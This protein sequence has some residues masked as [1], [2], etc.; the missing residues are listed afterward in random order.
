[1]QLLGFLGR[2]LLSTVFWVPSALAADSREKQLYG[3]HEHVLLPEFD[4]PL[5]AKLDTGAKTASLHAQGI[6]RFKRGGKSWVRFYLGTDSEQVQPVEMPLLRT[7]RIKRRADDMDEDDDD[8]RSSSR[9]PV[10]ALS[11]CLGERV[12]QIEVNLTDRSAFHYP[13]LIGADA[14]RQFSAQ[15]DPALEHLAGAPSCHSSVAQ[16]TE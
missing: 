11:V 14:L 12:Q 6:E 4:L 9:R 2:L 1:M 10:V 8:A 5:E 16:T 13:L 7:S 15:V 3:L